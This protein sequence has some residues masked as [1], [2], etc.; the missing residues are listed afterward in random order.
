MSWTPCP[1]PTPGDRASADAEGQAIWSAKGRVSLVE[2]YRPPS[3]VLI[4]VIKEAT[5]A[6]HQP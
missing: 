1:D 4:E 6:E 3:R 5:S 2:I